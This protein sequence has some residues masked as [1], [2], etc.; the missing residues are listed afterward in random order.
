MNKA[1]KIST[2]LYQAW[3][4]IEW[5]P[6]TEDG[7]LEQILD[8]KEGVEPDDAPDSAASLFKLAF[9]DK[10]KHELPQADI[11]FFRRRG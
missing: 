7:Y 6:E 4:Y 10:L 11:D 3:R 8:W 5:A 9:L 2:Y 1:V